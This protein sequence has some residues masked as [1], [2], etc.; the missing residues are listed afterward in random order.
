MSITS[1]NKIKQNKRK[2][3]ALI[4]TT[5]NEAVAIFLNENFHFK[6]GVWL[7]A[8]YVNILFKSYVLE[9]TWNNE[10][11]GCDFKCKT[12][13]ILKWYQMGQTSYPLS[14]LPF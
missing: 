2:Q 13:Q 4:P 8:D 9:Q 1:T 7:K 6:E 5:A 10:F 11:I 3:Q 14:C 12:A